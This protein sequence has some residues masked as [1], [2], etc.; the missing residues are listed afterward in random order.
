MSYKNVDK[1]CKI[2]YQLFGNMSSLSYLYGIK[3]WEYFS[4][5]TKKQQKRY[6]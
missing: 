4:T 5:Q 1:M 6:E 3:G 2:V